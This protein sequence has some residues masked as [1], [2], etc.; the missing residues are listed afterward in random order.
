MGG[1]GGSVY[2][3]FIGGLLL[4]VMSAAERGES[5]GSA[6]TSN[7]P[8]EDTSSGDTNTDTRT[9]WAFSQTKTLN[10][11]TVG[12]NWEESQQVCLC[13]VRIWFIII[14][15]NWIY[16]DIQ[17]KTLNKNPLECGTACQS[18]FWRRIQECILLLLVTELIH[19]DYWSDISQELCPEFWIMSPPCL[20][21]RGTEN[22]YMH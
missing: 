19:S 21:I 10:Y 14:R 6:E 16:L 18:I 8:H 1:G 15:M 12:L 17:R 3:Q 13:I 5:A 22:G 20:L 4:A 11:A 2:G 9:I 7:W